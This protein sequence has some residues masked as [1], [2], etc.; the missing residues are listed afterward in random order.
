MQIYTKK[1]VPV[2]PAENYFSTV[3]RGCVG[4]PGADAPAE[5]GWSA[6]DRTILGPSPD[7]PRTIPGPRAYNAQCFRR[8]GAVCLR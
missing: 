8:L 1:S 3:P 4:W 6:G 5:R 7:H 2:L